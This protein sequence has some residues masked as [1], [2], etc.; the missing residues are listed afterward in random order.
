MQ[1][2]NLTITSLF[3]K[4]IELRLVGADFK[5]EF[6]TDLDDHITTDFTLNNNSR[7]NPQQHMLDW[8]NSFIPKGNKF[9]H[10]TEKNIKTVNDK[11]YITNDYYFSQPMQAVEMKLN[12]IITQNPILDSSLNRL[13]NHPLIR[14][15][16]HI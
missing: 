13:H 7:I 3:T 11:L 10:L 1:I 14:I 2:K 16:S 12:M 9:S 6:D 15:Y 8:I 4:K 5:M